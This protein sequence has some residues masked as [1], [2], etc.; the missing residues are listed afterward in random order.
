MGD[1]R[2]PSGPRRELIASR[3]GRV[4][5]VIAAAWPDVSRARI[6]RLIAE[7]N[8][9]VDGRPVRK[10]ASV[11]IGARIEVRLESGPPVRRATVAAEGIEILFEDDRLIAVSK[12]AAVVV[13]DSAGA[14]APSVA[15]WFLGRYPAEADR[16]SAGRPGIVHRLD[17]DTTGVLVLAKDPHSQHLISRAFEK[18]EVAKTYV[19]I[20]GGRPRHEK[21]SVETSIGRDPADRTRMAVVAHGRNAVTEFE[22]V[23]HSDDRSL[24][25]VRPRTGRTHQIRV[26]LSA[27]GCPVA[28]DAVY[29]RVPGPRQMLHAWRIA[30]PHP[31]GGSLEVTAPLPADFRLCAESSGLGRDVVR[32]CESLPARRLP[33]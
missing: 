31:G 13:H 29:G 6:Q 8:V 12:P 3:A 15:G 7:G 24:I 9:T 14:P 21:G 1:D 30:V 27:V 26:H 5:A 33:D 10:S 25:E 18:R 32:Y 11:S 17:K 19:A 28:G 16:F 2:V 20:C 22:V 4:D 23:A